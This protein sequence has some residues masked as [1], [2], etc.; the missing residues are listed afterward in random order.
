LTFTPLPLGASPDVL[1]TITKK[2][3]MLALSSVA[4]RRLGW[5]EDEPNVSVALGDGEDAGWL[6]IFLDEDGVTPEQVE[7]QLVLTLPR[8]A[9]PD[10]QDC[11]ASPLTWRPAP[12]GAG[13]DVRLPTVSAGARRRFQ[14]KVAVNNE[15]RA[16]EVPGVSVIAVPDLYKGLHREAYA[17]GVELMFLSD[18]NV[19]VNGKVSPIDDIESIVRAAIERRNAAR[20]RAG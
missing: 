20:E 4:I 10:L 13:I 3:V 7:K 17:V 2:R 1:A 6:R 14:P 12:E 18:G 8:S 11:R 16:D 9:L 5:S 19:L 15:A